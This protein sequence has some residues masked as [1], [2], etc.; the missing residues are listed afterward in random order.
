MN[1]VVTGGTG[2]IGSHIVR[3][4]R[5]HF[6]DA[7]ITVVDRIFRAHALFGVDNFIEEDYSCEDVLQLFEENDIDCVVHC[8]GT[9]LV[10]PSVVDPS[11]YYLN[12]VSK[13]IMM[14]DAI[15]RNKKRP[16]VLFSSSAA[17]YGECWPS[18]REDAVTK[19]TNPYG[20]TK[21]M[22]EKVLEDY[23]KA[24]GIP[25]V[26]FR[27][28]NAAG[29]EPFSYDLGQELGAT[30]IVARILEAKLFDRTFTL[31][32]TDYDT[33]DGT[34]VR[35]YIH[36][37]DIA[38]AHVRALLFMRNLMTNQPTHYTFNL[39][40]SKGFSNLEI[41]DYVEKNIGPVDVC[42]RERRP[43]DPAFLVAN[44]D[45]AWNTIGWTPR[46]S[47]ISTIIN[48]AHKWY[49]NSPAVMAFNRR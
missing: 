49:L 21:L 34:C 28:F 25:Y 3:A 46:F 9:S 13:T 24:Y 23:N 47:E 11:N 43:G 16:V 48:S 1:I 36:V 2:Y 29:A 17:V 27:F 31:Y 45:L 26:A 8:A 30:H 37:W 32:G 22:I 35:D 39:G 12:N 42:V 6:P 5:N 4:M 7:Y 41:L 18:L 10:G 40:T 15:R 33:P 38:R 44:G 19:P 14:M 20:N